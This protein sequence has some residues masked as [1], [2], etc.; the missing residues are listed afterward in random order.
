MS[1]ETSTH[2]P[3]KKV[4]SLYER[5]IIGNKTF[6]TRKLVNLK[7]VDGGSIA[8][9]LNEVQSIM[10]LLFAVKMVMDDELQALL[11]PSSLPDS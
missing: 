5:K 8:E 2:S 1:I 9:H 10:N 6:L 4:E 3:W 11:L 7:Y